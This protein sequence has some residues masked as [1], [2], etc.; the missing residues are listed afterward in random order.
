MEKITKEDIKETLNYLFN[1][2]SD[3]HYTP[4]LEEFHLGFE[5]EYKTHDGVRHSKEH[6]DSLP[7]QKGVVTSIED[8]AYIK[9]S[10]TGRM[11]SEDGI[12]CV[13]VPYVTMSDIKNELS[14][15]APLPSGSVYTYM[16]GGYGKFGQS[17]LKITYNEKN[18]MLHIQSTANVD[19]DWITVYFNG[20]LQNI[21][22]LRNIFYLC[23]VK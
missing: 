19:E 13:R 4:T 12:E 20:N 18:R 1:I 21:N 10:L 3:T 22:E 6:M 2:K 15:P 16:K 11:A 8:F 14:D 9:R 23:K 7:W 17:I 5:Y